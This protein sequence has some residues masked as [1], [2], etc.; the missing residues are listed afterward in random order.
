MNSYI[1]KLALLLYLI[2]P[3]SYAD[4]VK[5]LKGFTMGNSYKV[6]WREAA[7]SA[8][9]MH[10]L[11]TE[12][13]LKLAEINAAMSTWDKQSELSLIN[14]SD[15]PEL[16]IS[17]ELAY[18]VAEAKRLH[19]LT[20]GALDV[21]LA[22]LIQLWG[23][24]VSGQITQA[25]SQTE[26]DA[27]LERTGTANFN[28]NNTVLQRDISQLNI[29]LSS[30]AKGHG[31]D[32]IANLLEQ[33]GITHYLVDIGGELKLKGEKYPGRPW[34]VGI[35]KPYAFSHGQMA[36]I[37]PGNR[38]VA[39]SGDYRRYFE[40]NGQHFS[41]ILDPN[42]GKPV[43]NNIVSVTVLADLCMTADGLATAFMVLPVIDSLQIAN[44]N[45]IPLMIIKEEHGK[46]VT[47][48]SNTFEKYINQ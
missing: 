8:D 17:A 35:D 47:H 19:Q 12:I 48:Y 32:V 18:V 30:I 10:Q 15:K 25:P 7:I 24:G 39:T 29:D 22:P 28:L 6:T 26:I 33:H 11:S 2:S 14:Q 41:H 23:F 38:A 9:R 37:T 42:T 36:V 16:P 27:A 20:H 45:H 13:D 3:L 1:A 21:T 4:D 44:N 5:S 40:S 46:L 43:N 31:V 34:Q